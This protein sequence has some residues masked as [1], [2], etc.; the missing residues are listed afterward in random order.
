M[1][2]KPFKFRFANELAGGFILLALLLVVL[3][4]AASGRVKDLFTRTTT[5]TL[6]LPPEGSL[7]LREG[8]EVLML[9]TPIGTVRSVDPPSGDE[10]RM[11]ATISVR[12]NF[13]KFMRADSEYPPTSGV[14]RRDSVRGWT[15]IPASVIRKWCTPR[16]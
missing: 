10:G 13:L 7:G 4:V 11:T 2:N 6:H 9:G 16:R 8:A 12:S 1:A 3:A 15:M 14:T 5:I